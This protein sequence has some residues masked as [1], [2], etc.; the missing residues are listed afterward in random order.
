MFDIFG[1][2]EVD[3]DSCLPSLKLRSLSNTETE[4][5]VVPPAPALNLPIDESINEILQLVKYISN[6][7]NDIKVQ[8]KMKESLKCMD[9]FETKP[10]FVQFCKNCGRYLGCFSCVSN[11]QD[12]L[13]CRKPLYKLSCP[14]CESDIQQE[15]V[16]LFIPDLPS[17]LGLEDIPRPDII[18]VSSNP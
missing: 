2:D 15:I 4:D 6:K 12:C 10:N 18:R 8:E 3:D 1:D 17:I 5:F 9:C 7:I 14:T 11:L 13:Q 16:P